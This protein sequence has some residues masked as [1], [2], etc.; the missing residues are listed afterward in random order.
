M[1]EFIHEATPELILNEAL[2]NKFTPLQKF[3]T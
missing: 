3:N 2:R 1:Q